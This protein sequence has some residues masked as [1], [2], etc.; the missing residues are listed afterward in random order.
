MN[1]GKAEGGLKVEVRAEGIAANR[2]IEIISH[3][4]QMIRRRESLI[5]RCIDAADDPVRF[6][7]R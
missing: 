6:V 1:G 5:F 3:P 4:M 2:L 7:R